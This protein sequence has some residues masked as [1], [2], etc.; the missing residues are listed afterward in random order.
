MDRKEFLKAGCGAGLC[1]CAGMSFLTQL[2]CGETTAPKVEKP[3]QEQPAA[4]IQ[5][6]EQWIKKV[7]TRLLET[8]EKDVDEPTR[9]KILMSMGRECAN[10]YGFPVK[11]KGQP[12]KFW[13]E[14]IKNWKESAETAEYDKE[15][16]VI[17]FASAKRTNCTCVFADKG[18]TPSYFCHCSLGWATE[19][20]ANVFKTPVK[21]EL[22]ESVLQGGSRCAFKIQ[23]LS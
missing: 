20:F 2:A 18:K 15:K 5:W 9:Q 7:F 11:Y 14:E 3:A 13:N 10:H 19:V 16:G 23:L 8:M 1:A 17:T 6:K 21:V 22:V 12:E 4:E